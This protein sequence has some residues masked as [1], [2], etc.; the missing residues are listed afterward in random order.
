MSPGAVVAIYIGLV[1]FYVHN[2]ESRLY[3]LCMLLSLY[4]AYPVVLWLQFLYDAFY[5]A[6]FSTKVTFFFRVVVTQFLL[7]LLVLWWV[8]LPQTPL[9]VLLAGFAIGFFAAALGFSGAQFYAAMEPKMLFYTELGERCGSTFP[10]AVFFLFGFDPTSD[11][12]TFGMVVLCGGVACVATGCFLSTLHFAT[13]FFE[14]AYC[15]LARGLSTNRKDSANDQ[16]AELLLSTLQRD[17]EV[18]EASKP[19]LPVTGDNVP[20]WVWLWSASLA[21][22]AMLTFSSLSLSAFF[23]DVSLA[24]TLALVKVGSDLFGSLSAIPLRRLPSFETGP[25][26]KTLLSI[27]ILRTYLFA[28]QIAKLSGTNFS[29][30]FFMMN[31]S[32]FHSLFTLQRSLASV[33]TTSFVHL[34]D[35]RNV[36]RTNI[37]MISGGIVVGL[38]NTIAVVVPLLGLASNWPRWD[39]TIES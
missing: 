3:Y 27:L 9:S 37:G 13:D 33:T 28:I 11:L 29:Q 36:A 8:H 38:L 24:Q 39:Q 18:S 1:G 10:I 7:A 20:A 34:K 12:T 25:W 4:V 31:W 23:G 5:D 30:C 21:Y 16:D 26:H 14:K 2:F 6:V 15:R 35:R 17:R 32:L 19:L 22:G